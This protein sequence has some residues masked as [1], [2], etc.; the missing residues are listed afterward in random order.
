MTINLTNTP[1]DQP[2]EPYIEADGWY[3]VCRRC[4]TEIKPTDNVCSKCNQFQ[5]WSWFHDWKCKDE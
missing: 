5:D 3:A 2:I 1:L 4:W